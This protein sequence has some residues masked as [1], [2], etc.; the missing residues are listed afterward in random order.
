MTSSSSSKALVEENKGQGLHY[1]LL[2]IHK[3]ETE[4]E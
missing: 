2:R 4:K 3:V 1:I